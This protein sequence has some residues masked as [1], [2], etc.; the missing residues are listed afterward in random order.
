MRVYTLIQS[1]SKLVMYLW[2]ISEQFS[3]RTASMKQSPAYVQQCIFFRSC[4][5]DSASL[6]W[7]E[8]WPGPRR[9]A[10]SP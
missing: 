8:C 10:R 9:I 1:P 5:M 4:C 6:V 2:R 7:R 3:P